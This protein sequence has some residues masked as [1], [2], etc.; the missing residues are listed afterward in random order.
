MQFILDT[1]LAWSALQVYPSVIVPG[2]Y[3][4]LALRIQYKNMVMTC[5]TLVKSF[6]SF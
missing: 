6:N 4:G 2:V 5:V 1:Q 3:N